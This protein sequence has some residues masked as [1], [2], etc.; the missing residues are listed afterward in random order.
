MGGK[1]VASGFGCATGFE[2]AGEVN[3]AQSLLRAVLEGFDER[4]K[5]L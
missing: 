2:S 3:E 1:E 4:R 5:I